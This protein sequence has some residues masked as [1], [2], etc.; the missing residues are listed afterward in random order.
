MSEKKH[1]K[2]RAKTEPCLITVLVIILFLLS[3][4]PCSCKANEA[5]TE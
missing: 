4:K 1:K 5:S 2:G 3:S